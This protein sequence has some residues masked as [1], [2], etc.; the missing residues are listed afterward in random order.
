ML[1]KWI[2]VILALTLLMFAVPA[3]GE[4]N[5]QQATVT[6]LG[7]ATVTLIPDMA[8]FTVGVSTQD[9]QVQTAQ[10][11]NAQIMQKVLDTLKTAGVDAKD[12]QTDNYSINPVY[13]YQNGK[14][15]SQQVLKGY[16]VSNTVT[17][18]VRAL[19]QLPSLLDTAVGAGANV[20]YGIN[21]QSSQN[22]A[23]YDQALAAATK[24]ALRKAKLIAEALGRE[25]GNVLYAEEANDACV[26]YASSKAVA[27]DSATP[28]ETGT[29]T[30]SANVRVKVALQ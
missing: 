19:D 8:T 11:A 18:T 6:A 28:I 14:L 23:A 27:Y 2:V 13:D 24:D 10:Q 7:T 21:F 25:T 3:L 15:D 4:E 26:S 1:K 17:V 16:S 22:A 5:A 29:L 12:L 30:V 20:T 9:L